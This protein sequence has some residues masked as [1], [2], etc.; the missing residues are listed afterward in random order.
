MGSARWHLAR[1]RFRAGGGGGGEELRLDFLVFN[2]RWRGA[3][4]RSLA[5]DGAT[6]RMCGEEAVT[7]PWPWTAGRGEGRWRRREEER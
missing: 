5:I 1:R 6:V 7:P 3:L 2:W 4:T